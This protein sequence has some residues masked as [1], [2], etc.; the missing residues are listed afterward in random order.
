MNFF[1]FVNPLKNDINGL[2]SDSNLKLSNGGG[3]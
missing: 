2:F 3:I 1:D